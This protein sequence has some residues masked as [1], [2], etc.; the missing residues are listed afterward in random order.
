MIMQKVSKSSAR[1][2]I[3]ILMRIYIL[4]IYIWNDSNSCKAARS[5]YSN[6]RLLWHTVKVTLTN[7]ACGRLHT[8]LAVLCWA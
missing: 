4:R 7:V 8:L 2:R 5:I 1:L 6:S 3:Y